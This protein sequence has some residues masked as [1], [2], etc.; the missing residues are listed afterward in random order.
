MVTRKA[1][2]ADR[3]TGA[4]WSY[5]SATA[6]DGGRGVSA[7]PQTYFYQESATKQEGGNEV[8]TE[9]AQWAELAARARREWAED[10]P[11]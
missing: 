2:N 5:E 11:F 6:D 9:E 4:Q 10:N 7:W 3:W 1:T 8:D